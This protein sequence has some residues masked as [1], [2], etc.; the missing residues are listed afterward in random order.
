M[1]SNPIKFKNSRSSKMS[2]FSTA[3]VFAIVPEYAKLGGHGLAFTIAA[4]KELN[5]SLPSQYLGPLN[6]NDNGNFSNHVKEELY[7]KSFKTIQAWI[8][9]D[10][11]RNELNVTLSLSSVKPKFSV[12]SY[13]VDLSPIFRD[14]M[15]IGFS[16]STGLL[17][18]SH[19]VFGWSFKING[20]AKSLDL[21]SLPSLPGPKKDHTSFIII[22]SVCDVALVVFAIVLALYLVYK[23]KN[24]DVLEDWELDVG[25]HRFPY[26]E[27]KKETNGFR[28]KGLLGFGGFGRVYKGTLPNSGTLVAVKQKSHNSKQGLREFASGIASIGRLRHINLVQLLG[29]CRRKGDLLL[30]YDFM[31]NGSLDRYIYDEPKMILTWKQRF[32]II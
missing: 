29:W 26:K 6:A 21:S 22:V 9:Y 3:F 7:L 17:A 16:S 18:R 15:Y 19:Y 11:W 5:G 32:K 8:D 27:L 4:E 1:S 24:M 12:L 13:H 23:I 10:S 2:S 28:D 25:P 30:V 31:P 20:E 14:S